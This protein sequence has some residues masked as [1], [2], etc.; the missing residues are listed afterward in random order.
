MDNRNNIAFSNPLLM[1]GAVK[2]ALALAYDSGMLAG[3]QKCLGFVAK[4]VAVGS[5]EE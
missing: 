2:D 3:A 1:R 4:S 5:V